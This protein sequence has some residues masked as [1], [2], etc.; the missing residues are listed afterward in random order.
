MRNFREAV[1]V[2]LKVGVSCRAAKCRVVSSQ[3]SAQPIYWKRG[4][5]IIM[6]VSF[7]SFKL[8][9]NKISHHD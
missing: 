8:K 2:S 4:N 9:L 3:N 1:K 6:E 5:G 7:F